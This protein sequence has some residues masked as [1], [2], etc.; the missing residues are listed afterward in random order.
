MM[1]RSCLS[2]ART[3]SRIDKTNARGPI[4]LLSIVVLLSETF[5]RLVD[6]FLHLFDVVQTTLVVSKRKGTREVRS[7]RAT[8]IEQ[9]A[10]ASGHGHDAHCRDDGRSRAAYFRT[11][12]GHGW[13]DCRRSIHSSVM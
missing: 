7:V 3:L 2:S 8:Q 9:H 11:S 12:V 6:R 5:E 10:V 1:K 13:L 4:S